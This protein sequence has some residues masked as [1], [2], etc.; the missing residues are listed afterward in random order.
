MP[1]EPIAPPPG[2]VTAFINRDTGKPA[3]PGDPLSMV[4]YFMEGTIPSAE[5][6][7]VIGD[8]DTGLGESTREE[9]F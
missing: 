1:E 8:P 4:E 7:G 6:G 3:D 2:I 5:A 9:L